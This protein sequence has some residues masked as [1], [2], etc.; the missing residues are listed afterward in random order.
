MGQSATPAMYI[1]AQSTPRSFHLETVL[2]AARRHQA[3]AFDRLCRLFL[4]RPIRIC[5]PVSPCLPIYLAVIIHADPRPFPVLTR[6]HRP[7]CLRASS[8]R[9][10]PQP[11]TTRFNSRTDIARWPAPAPAAA[12]IARRIAP[13]IPFDECDHAHYH[14]ICAA[15]SL[16]SPYYVLYPAWSQTSSSW[17]T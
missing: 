2:R 1:H 11:S 17:A 7:P 8:V 3:D 15:P 13:S 4:C 16:S 10:L 6:T 12:L 5:F 14:N 9:P